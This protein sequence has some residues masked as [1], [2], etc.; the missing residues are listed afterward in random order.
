MLPNGFHLK[1]RRPYESLHSTISFRVLATQV[2]RTAH[3]VEEAVSRSPQI[4]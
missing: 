1:F 4:T 3:R 2:F